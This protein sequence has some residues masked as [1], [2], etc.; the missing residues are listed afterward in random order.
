MKRLIIGPCMV[1]LFFTTLI[2]ANPN[3]LRCASVARTLASLPTPAM[4]TPSAAKSMCQVAVG[5]ASAG[6]NLKDVGPRI[7]TEDP[8][9]KYPR[10][11]TPAERKVHE[12]L[13][14]L[15]LLWQIDCALNGPGDRTIGDKKLDPHVVRE[16]QQIG[17]RFG[18]DG[19]DDVNWDQLEAAVKGDMPTRAVPYFDI[20]G[21]TKNLNT[22]I[23][24]LNEIKNDVAAIPDP[25]F[26]Y[27]T[28][29]DADINPDGLTIDGTTN[30]KG[31]YRLKENVTYTGTTN[32]AIS[33]TTDD[34]V[35]DLGG[36]TLRGTG[37]N[38]DGVN[39]SGSRV[40]VKNGRIDYT[41]QS[42]NSTSCVQIVGTDAIVRD[43]ILTRG[44]HG[45]R[46]HA[47]RGTVQC[48]AAYQ[49]TD[50][51]FYTLTDGTRSSSNAVFDKCISMFNVGNGY[52]VLKNPGN[53][54]THVFRDCIAANNS[55][56]DG[57][58][59]ILQTSG[60]SVT[61]LCHRCVSVNNRYNFQIYAF[62]GTLDLALT[63]AYARGGSV[64]YQAGGGGSFNFTYNP[65]TPPGTSLNTAHFWDC[66][67]L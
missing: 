46:L 43:V 29:G 13:R 7:T 17:T 16:C 54:D 19:M 36:Y 61:D 44:Y 57:F 23:A 62:A 55:S 58:V 11:A 15:D 2:N 1:A 32:P 21:F 28:I 66:I 6:I 56:S 18:L 67:N 31:V 51:G 64:N 4:R 20:V 41:G 40:M 38:V 60:T 14:M 33:V 45:C 12:C 24:G 5:A 63:G 42:T 8:C 26:C 37:A 10:L 49:N 35:I 65:I 39:I 48:C 52:H 53:D 50:A 9:A 47:E 22:I 27:Q 34:V 30:P 25:V 3:M 59:F